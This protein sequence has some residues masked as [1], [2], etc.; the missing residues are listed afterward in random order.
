MNRPPAAPRQSSHRK[1]RGILPWMLPRPATLAQLPARMLAATLQ[2]LAPAGGRPTIP[3]PAERSPAEPATIT[4]PRASRAGKYDEPL[5]TLITTRPGI[6]V[7]Q[8]AEELGV[9]ATALYPT[10][11][12]LQPAGQLI[13]RGR[14]LH[15]AGRA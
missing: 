8:A 3:A 4:A 10:I 5:L 14:E 13:K 7:A 1:A 9:P 2:H 15:P 6:T 11:R 12:R